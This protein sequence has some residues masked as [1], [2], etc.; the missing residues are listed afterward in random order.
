[1]AEIYRDT[2]IEVVQDTEK[3]MHINRKMFIVR[4]RW[5]SYAINFKY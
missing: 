2:V 4:Y 5:K 3:G 1:M